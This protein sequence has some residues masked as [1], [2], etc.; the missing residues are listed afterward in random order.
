[1]HGLLNV[2]APVLKHA[3]LR[4]AACVSPISDDSTATASGFWMGTVRTSWPRL[5]S[6]TYIASVGDT[7]GAMLRELPRRRSA[8]GGGV[9]V[10]LMSVVF[11]WP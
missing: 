6:R 3:F 1:M 5:Y 4:G 11:V 7:V 2:L 10:S 8:A 9:G